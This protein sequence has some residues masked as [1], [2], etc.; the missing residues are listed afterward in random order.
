[1]NKNE[2]I[3]FFKDLLVIVII[4]VIVRTFLIMPFQINGQSMYSSYYNKEFI[5]IDRLSYYFTE[6]KRGDVVVFKPYVSSERVYFLKR[7]L[8][9]PGDTLKIED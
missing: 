9:I 6:P 7:I 4:V 5:I 1:M 8:A 3:D 2:I